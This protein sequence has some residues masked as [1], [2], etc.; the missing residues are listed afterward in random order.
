[1]INYVTTPAVSATANITSGKIELGDVINCS[2][3]ANFSGSD[4]AGTFKIQISNDGTNYVDLS[5]ASASITSSGDTCINIVDAG[6]RYIRYD[7]AYTSGTGNIKVIFNAKGALAKT[8]L[9]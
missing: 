3:Y 7:W 8:R 5:G 4:V 2:V 9:R 1:M 6:Y